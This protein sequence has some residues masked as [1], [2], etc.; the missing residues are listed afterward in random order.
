MLLFVSTRLCLDLEYNR[1][2]AQFVWT[3]VA[4]WFDFECKTLLSNAVQLLYSSL[5]MSSHILMCFKLH[6]YATD[7]IF[8]INIGVR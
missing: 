5:W 6:S 7:Y 8:G 4:Y 1:I 3:S 2:S